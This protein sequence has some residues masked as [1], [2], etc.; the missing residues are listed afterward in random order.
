MKILHYVPNFSVTTETFIYDQIKGV[1]NAGHSSAV[2]T[3]KRSNLD[4]RPFTNVYV[5]PF[6]KLVNERISGIL[7]FRLQLLPL[8]IDYR[9]WEEVLR[10]FQPDIIHCHAGNALKTWMHVCD[11]LKLTIPTLV[12]MHGSDVNSEPLIRSQYR[13]VLS[14]AGQQE[15]IHWTV[16]SK[17][18]KIKAMQNLNVPAHKISVVYNAVNT[19][20]REV[21]EKIDF[22]QPRIVCVGRFIKCKGHENLIRAFSIV[23][24]HYPNA[25]LT[26]IGTGPLENSLLKL[27]KALGIDSQVNLIS[28]IEHS[29]LPRELVKHNLYVQPS[30]KDDV[31]QQEESFGVAALEA[32]VAGLPTIVTDSGGLSEIAEALDTDEICVVKKSDIASLAN[33]IL[34]QFQKRQAVSELSRTKLGEFFSGNQNIMNI[35]KLYNN[36]I[37]NP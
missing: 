1:E 11:K 33:S 23:V 17:F 8:F 4:S 27:I 28:L 30:I 19:H 12:S 24:K 13:R 6:R 29:K 10:D 15:H 31:T 32:V 9:K 26:L 25:T 34:S 16:P 18:L 5:C 35:S 36:L 2:L 21:S 14:R 37:E 20:F 7:S 22:E 3:A